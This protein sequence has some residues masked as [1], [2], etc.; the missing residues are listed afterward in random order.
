[1]EESQFTVLPVA[2]SLM[3]S[4]IPGKSQVTRMQYSLLSKAHVN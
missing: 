1:M 2:V 4:K 3:H